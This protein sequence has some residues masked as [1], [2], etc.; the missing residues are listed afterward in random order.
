MA[1]KPSR[2]ETTITF[3][4]ETG[5]ERLDRTV[6]A[7]IPELSRAIAQRLIKEGAVTV[8]GRVSKPSYCTQ[9]GDEIRVHV[10][11]EPPP[12]IVA[13]PIP[14]AVLYEDDALLVIDKPA[15]MVV[16]PAAGHTRGTL[17]N[18]LL[19][20]CPQIADVGGAGRAGIVHRLDKNTSGLILVAKDETAHTALQR[21]FK[22][23]QVLK[24]YLALVEG[25][26]HPREGIIEAPMGRDKRQRKKMAVVQSGRE[27]RTQYRVLEYLPDHTLLEVYPQT[28][29]T[30]QVRVHLAWLG[31]PVA[32]DSLYGRRRQ[33]LL[34]NRHFLHAA[35][36]RFA[37]PVTGDELAFESPLPAELAAALKKLRAGRHG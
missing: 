2:P 9:A 14:L 23:R 37:H 6:A 26:V 17:V 1:Q 25:R 8:N 27:A 12:E 19:A 29:R 4:V 20:R 5:G 33:P 15:G 36:L 28:G 31:Y 21:Q 11:A 10:P 22:H 34:Q 24:T 3:T 32:G 7:H 13:E 16:H 18:A 30:H 35:R